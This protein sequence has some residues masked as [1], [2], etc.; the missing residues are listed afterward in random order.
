MA[1]EILVQHWIHIFFGASMRFR[2]VHHSGEE[3]GA[4]GD[5][6]ANWTWWTW[7]VLSDRARQAPRILRQQV[8][9]RCSRWWN[10][11]YP[12]GQATSL[13]HETS[14]KL[15]FFHIPILVG[16]PGYPINEPCPEVPPGSGWRRRPRST[17]H[18]QRS[19][20]PGNGGLGL[21]SDMPNLASSRDIPWRLPNTQ[22]CHL[23]IGRWA[24]WPIRNAVGVWSFCIAQVCGF[25]ALLSSNHLWVKMRE[26]GWP[27]RTCSPI[28][29][30]QFYPIYMY[31]MY[32]YTY[33]P[34]I[35]EWSGYK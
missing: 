18:C 33:I 27:A 8:V 14:P 13:K 30:A 15:V 20:L 1:Q 12:I 10:P 21:A 31:Y 2:S 28:Y 34:S 32:I 7:L 35:R 9:C 19:G 16:W 17:Y 11:G 29:S 24:P 22:E 6:W 25:M 26:S 3:I 4:D 5:R 23:C